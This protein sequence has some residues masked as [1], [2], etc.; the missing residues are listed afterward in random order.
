M[1]APV[2]AV[3]E[4]EVLGSSSPIHEVRMET[5]NSNRDAVAG[6]PSVESPAGSPPGSDDS[7]EQRD[8]SLRS[9]PSQEEAEDTA[10]AAV[11]APTSTA[12]ATIDTTYANRC[13]SC[14][15]G[16]GGGVFGRWRRWRAGERGDARSEIS[17]SVSVREA[18][19]SSQGS[20]SVA[21]D[22]AS[23][24]T[25]KSSWKGRP[26]SSWRKNSGIV[27]KAAAG[28]GKSTAVVF[29]LEQAESLAT[30][31]WGGG[32]GSAKD[33]WKELVPAGGGGKAGVGGKGSGGGVG[34][35]GPAVRLRLRFVPLWDCIAVSRIMFMLIGQCQ[36]W[37]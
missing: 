35:A 4:P 15:P 13:A 8:P 6:L 25:K 9:S 5:L 27:E 31:G 32:S 26:G 24:S 29:S 10:A 14:L 3:Q 23:D 36:H 12:A 11:A 33:I 7:G 34:I 1:V 2:A 30:S 19:V 18:D 22:K 21:A 37:R 16:G 28:E 20:G 17:D